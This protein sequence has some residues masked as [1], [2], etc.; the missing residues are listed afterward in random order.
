M[1]YINLRFTYL[2][3][4]LLEVLLE[5]VSLEVWRRKVSGLVHIGRAGRREFQI[6]EAATLKLRA[7]N[8][9]RTNRT[10]SRLVFDNLREPDD[11]A[12]LNIDSQAEWNG[13]CGKWCWLLLRKS[14]RVKPRVTEPARL[15]WQTAVKRPVFGRCREKSSVW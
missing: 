6:L 3:T 10:E 14:W 4:Y 9:V 12:R 1:R 7:P 15:T 13:E 8:E 5:I 11:H 2:L